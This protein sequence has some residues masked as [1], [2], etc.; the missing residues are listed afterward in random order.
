MIE[1]GDRLVFENAFFQLL[2]TKK[3]LH[4]KEKKDH[5]DIGTTIEFWYEMIF[6]ESQ[7]APIYYYNCITLDKV[8]I[9]SSTLRLICETHTHLQPNRI[10]PTAKRHFDLYYIKDNFPTIKEEMTE[11]GMEYEIE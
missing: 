9:W 1:F 10:F 6:K 2:R 3:I 4:T 5:H 7:Q 11:L 8:L